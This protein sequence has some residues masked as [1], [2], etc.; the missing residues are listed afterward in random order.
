MV[1]GSTSEW[2]STIL[3]VAVFGV[4]VWAA[5]S[6]ALGGAAYLLAAGVASVLGLGAPVFWPFVAVAAALVAAPVL[7]N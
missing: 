1:T 6:L 3:G 4:L 2:L 5:L 7:L